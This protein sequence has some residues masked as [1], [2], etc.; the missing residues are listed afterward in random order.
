MLLTPQQQTGAERVL[1]FL[2]QAVSLIPMESWVP[3]K[4]HS[5]S[6]FFPPLLPALQS[7]SHESRINF[8]CFGVGGDSLSLK[9]SLFFSSQIWGLPTRCHW[10]SYF[11]YAILTF[12]L[13][14][15][16][17]EEVL[18]ISQKNSWALWSPTLGSVYVCFKGA[19]LIMWL[20]CL[21]VTWTFMCIKAFLIVSSYSLFP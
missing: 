21:L 16:F 20:I 11:Y 2:I 10:L 12:V 14:W 9:L 7:Q 8:N 1:C 15:I 17:T 19:E 4:G 6:P 18:N 3:W 13:G 5:F